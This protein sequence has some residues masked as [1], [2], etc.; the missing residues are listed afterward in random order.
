[1]INLATNWTI[2]KPM[3][4]LSIGQTLQMVF[5]TLVIGGFC[6][7]ILGIIL[8]GSSPN[9]LFPNKI[10]YGILNFIINI[11]RPIPFIIF[12][13]AVQPLT[14]LAMGTYIGTEAVIFPM[15]L[16][17]TFATS[18]LVEQSL[19]STDKTIIE[20]AKSMGASTIKIIYSVLIPESLAP[21]VLGYAFLFV[22]ILDMS[23][24]AG[25]LGGGGLG[26]F[27]IAYG[28]QK[29]DTTVTWT[30]VAIIVVL[31]QIVQHIGNFLAKKLM[32]K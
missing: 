13:T 30:A 26:N 15:C 11:V 6:G 8:Y 31:V 2:L 10:L 24:M 3:L 9:S 25:A 16:M 22:A 17:C 1:M 28:Y 20:A 5:L 7:L 32:H 29:F 21:L 19:V 27:A 4:F 18:R 23:A 12:L 14:L